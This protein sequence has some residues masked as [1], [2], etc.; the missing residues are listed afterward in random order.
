MKSAQQRCTQLHP[1]VL[2]VWLA[3][4]GGRSPIASK[5]MSRGFL[6]RK[7]SWLSPGI[8]DILH[9][10]NFQRQRSCKIHSWAPKIFSKKFSQVRFCGLYFNTL[11][12][13][14][15]SQKTVGRGSLCLEIRDSSLHL[16]HL[17]A[18]IE[19]YRQQQ[20]PSVKRSTL[21]M[22]CT[23]NLPSLPSVAFMVYKSLIFWCGV[24]NFIK[25]VGERVVASSW[26]TGYF[27]LNVLRLRGAM[28]SNVLSQTA[29]S[30][31]LLHLS[32]SVIEGPCHC[33]TVS[34][35]MVGRG[36]QT[37]LADKTWR[38]YSFQPFLL[39]VTKQSLLQE[40][41]KEDKDE[42]KKP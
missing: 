22:K 9:G 7:E 38:L 6:Q 8:S 24:A 39:V 1:A 23:A 30:R 32:C 20:S 29:Q 14:C 36:T 18:L 4:E 28:V 35:N 42:K 5:S 37:C 19:M 17:T 16:H 3:Q 40:K 15:K 27:S 33:G 34:G 2:N 21:K 10:P 31:A 26:E 41:A 11:H 13:K 12:K 25:K